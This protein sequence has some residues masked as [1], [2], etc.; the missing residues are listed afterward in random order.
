MFDAVPRALFVLALMAGASDPGALL[1][2]ADAPHDGFPEGLIALRVVLDEHGKKPVE[3]LLDLFVKGKDDSL[4]VFREGK[5]Q[6][7]K[8]LSI[9]DRVWL[10]VP[11]AS[12]PI[13]VSKSQRLMGAA[14]FGDIA[15]MRFADSYDATVRSD[16]GDVVL[17]L[18]A[19]NKGAAYPKGVLWVGREDGLPR[20]LR[21]SL[22]S[23]KEAKEI[24]F[25]A[26]GPDHRLKTMEIRD[27]LSTGGDN[28]TTLT[29]ERYEPRTLEPAMFDPAG[30][31]VLQ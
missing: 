28:K 10:I 2:R 22:A 11:G 6:G 16:E 8:I 19:K 27:L 7:R 24:R 31:R 13:P 23:G 1:R 18:A 29:F 26:Y 25:L 17:D 12:R 5:Q 21:L 15:R 20:K 4:C 14:S 30:T 3:S 9:G